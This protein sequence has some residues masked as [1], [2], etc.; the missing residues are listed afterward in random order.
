MKPIDAETLRVIRERTLDM[1]RPHVCAVCEPPGVCCVCG[2]P[3]PCDVVALLAVA[4]AVMRFTTSWADRATLFLGLQCDQI[5]SCEEAELLA[6]LWRLMGQ[7]Q[8][9]QEVID[10][11]A[12]GE[13]VS[14]R[15]HHYE[16]VEPGGPGRG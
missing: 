6:D 12:S 10:C 15:R 2:L 8:V 16:A 9:A 13:P 5:E 1:H 4:E 7:P 14:V 11:H 3:V